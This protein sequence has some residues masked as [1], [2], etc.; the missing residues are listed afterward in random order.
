MIDPTGLCTQLDILCRG[1]KAVAHTLH[2]ITHFLTCKGHVVA[3]FYG[4]AGGQCSLVRRKLL[5]ELLPT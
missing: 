3:T 2:P 1:A 4:V 5:P